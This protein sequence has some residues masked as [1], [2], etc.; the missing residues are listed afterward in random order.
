MQEKLKRQV[1]PLFGGYLLPFDQPYSDIITK[2]QK[3][4]LVIAADG[5]I[6]SSAAAN[7]FAVGTRDTRPF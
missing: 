1:L 4:G 5:Y 6:A 7:I 3:G 2:V